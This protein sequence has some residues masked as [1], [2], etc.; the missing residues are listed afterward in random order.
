MLKNLLNNIKYVCLQSKLTA[1]CVPINTHD[2]FDYQSPNATC[3]NGG[4]CVA[5]NN[6]S[7]S[8]DV[9]LKNIY[10]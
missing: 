6:C 2:E 9:H 8:W 3:Q 5:P 1:M 4:T 10:I 7:V